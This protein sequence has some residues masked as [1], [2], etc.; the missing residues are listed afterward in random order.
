MFKFKLDQVVFYLA[1][2]K[3][4]SAKIQSR[5]IVENLHDDWASTDTQKQMW[6][7]WGPSAIT[8]RTVDGEY[9]E[10]QLFESREAL[11]STF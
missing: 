3:I 11:T 4:H 9:S 6:Q 1:S 8:Y 10:D 7:P 5:M 2:N